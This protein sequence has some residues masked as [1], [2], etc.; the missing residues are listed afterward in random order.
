MQFH[1]LDIT[2]KDYQG[3]LMEG[4]SV[5]ISVIYDGI[6]YE[7]IYWY[8][9]NTNLIILDD[10]LELLIGP[11]QELPEYN[12]IISYLKET[13]PEFLSIKDTLNIISI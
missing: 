3:L 13:C 6:V 5:L 10:D 11:I 1:N 9:H 7:C 12:N 2:I 8:N 4:V